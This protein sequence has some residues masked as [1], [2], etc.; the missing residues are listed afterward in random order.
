MA[1]R[2]GILEIFNPLRASLKLLQ[3]V[4]ISRSGVSIR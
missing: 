2:V 3:K 1:E 4:A